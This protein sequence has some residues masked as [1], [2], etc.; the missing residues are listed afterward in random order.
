MKGVGTP[1]LLLR[2]YNST[3][4]LAE[5]PLEGRSHEVG[6]HGPRRR[7]PELCCST[8]PLYK[9]WGNLPPWLGFLS[10]PLPFLS[11]WY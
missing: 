6:Y 11:R 7:L 4:I 5:P 2:F 8:C 3:A 1:D 10:L 9:P